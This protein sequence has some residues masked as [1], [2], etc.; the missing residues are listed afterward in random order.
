[1]YPSPTCLLIIFRNAFFRQNRKNCAAGSGKRASRPVLASRGETHGKQPA[2]AR[3]KQRNSQLASAAQTTLI[4]YRRV[5][6]DFTLRLQKFSLVELRTVL[7]KGPRSL[8]TGGDPARPVLGPSIRG[9]QSHRAR[10]IFCDHLVNLGL[11]IVRLAYVISLVT[12][13]KFLFAPA[14]NALFFVFKQD[15]FNSP[16]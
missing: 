13:L 9:D 3:G 4:I 10:A 6:N 5:I 1:M 14:A 2:G 11:K 16:F 7:P 12:K 15:S 8:D